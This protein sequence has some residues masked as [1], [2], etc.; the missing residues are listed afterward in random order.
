[1][2]EPDAALLPLGQ[3]EAP[4]AT[5]DLE[6]E[7]TWLLDQIGATLGGEVTIS[8]ASD[9]KLHVEGIVQDEARKREILAAL[10]PVRSNAAVK[11]YI[12]SYAEALRRSATTAHRIVGKAPGPSSGNSNLS[13]QAD[14]SE[15]LASQSPPPPE[16]ELRERVARLS[17]EISANSSNAARH[18]WVLR[19]LTEMAGPGDAENLSAPARRQY[20]SMVAGHAHAVEQSTRRLQLQ[21]APVFFASQPPPAEHPAFPMEL[22]SN[23]ARMLD[24]A[25]RTDKAIQSAFGISLGVES[26]VSIRSKE[27]H[28]SL[29]ET[30]ELACW[31]EKQAGGECGEIP[32]ATRTSP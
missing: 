19:H 7:T 2:F 3:G 5:P 24:A 4:A 26:P 29:F 30:E 1:M 21:L 27:F 9:Q 17:A 25:L 20:L 13:A 18:A 11:I 28:E 16:L 10:K 8:V 31:I 32:L 15:F 12:L 14:I 23:I 22:S 6:V